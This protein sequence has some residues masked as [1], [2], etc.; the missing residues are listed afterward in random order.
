MSSMM[1][2]IGCV[3]VLSCLFNICSCVTYGSAE[4]QRQIPSFPRKSNFFRPFDFQKCFLQYVLMS[5]GEHM[6]LIIEL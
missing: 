6:S 3:C 5:F 4:G 1:C 2:F